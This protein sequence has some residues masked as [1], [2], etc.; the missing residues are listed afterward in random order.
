MQRP[1]NHVGNAKAMFKEAWKMNLISSSPFI[2]LKGGSTPRENAR[3]VTPDDIA[4][5][6]EACPTTQWKLLFGL[7][8]YAGLRIP[9]ETRGLHWEHVDWEKGRMLIHSPKTEHHPGQESRL[10]PIDPR[11]LPLLQDAFEIAQEG[12]LKVLD[13]NAKNPNSRKF[14]KIVKQAGVEPWIS[15]F[16][17]LRASRE[18]EWATEY[19]GYAA[20][21]WL[22]HSEAVSH[23]HYTTVVPDELFSRA[24]GRE[25]KAA[26]NPAQHTAAEARTGLKRRVR[27]NWVHQGK[28]RQHEQLQ[29]TARGCEKTK[30]GAG[31]IRTPVP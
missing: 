12:D 24:A 16:Q 30:S 7:A 22:G 15:A 25:E 11:L 2:D 8:R 29:A 13:M 1:K 14:G 5:I 17:T 26:Q 23:R 19:P 20:S 27:E 18:I 4:R 10:V 3:Y 21:H 6:I 28:S 31:G 9:S